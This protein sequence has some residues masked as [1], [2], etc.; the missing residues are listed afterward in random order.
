MARYKFDKKTGRHI[1]VNESNKSN[2]KNKDTSGAGCVI[3]IL[4]VVA[5]IIW[6][7]L[8]G[9]CHDSSIAYDPDGF[10]GMSD[11]FWEWMGDQ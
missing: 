4:A 3:S 1:R 11:G 7:S 2:N 9:G 10:G 8:S 5:I 6:L